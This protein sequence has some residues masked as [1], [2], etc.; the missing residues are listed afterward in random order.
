MNMENKSIEKNLNEIEIYSVIAMAE[1]YDIVDN[2]IILDK[3]LA[4]SK[5]YDMYDEHK[6]NFDHYA[7][8]IDTWK[9]GVM[10]K[11]EYVDSNKNLVVEYEN[12]NV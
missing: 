12:H 2:Y 11:C 4:V 1:S 5:A 10:I 8:F 9:N 3:S 6:D 7:V